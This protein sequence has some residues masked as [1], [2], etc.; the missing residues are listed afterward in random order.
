[1][2]VSRQQ[3]IFWIGFSQKSQT[4]TIELKSDYNLI[5]EVPKY[6]TDVKVAQKKTYINLHHN[7]H[8]ANVQPSTNSRIDLDH[9]LKGIEAINRLGEAKFL[10]VSAHIK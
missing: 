7:E 9:N 1:M 4:N 5:Y 10:V 3:K 2:P 8:F 6:G